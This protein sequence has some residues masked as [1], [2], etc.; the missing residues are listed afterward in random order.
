MMYNGL[1]TYNDS[2]VNRQRYLIN[3]RTMHEMSYNDGGGY[4]GGDRMVIGFTT[5]YAISAY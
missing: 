3:I 1:D 5:T 4:R 2:D